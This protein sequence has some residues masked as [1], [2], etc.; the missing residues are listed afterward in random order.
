MAVDV[1]QPGA[2][3]PV[4]A[5]DLRRRLTLPAAADMQDPVARKRDIATLQV[6]VPACA[7]PR[8]GVP[9]D[10]PGGVADDG[11]GV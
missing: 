5:V 7:L 10:D 3:Q 2:D 1:H 6:A 9:G 8:I 11:N 4:G